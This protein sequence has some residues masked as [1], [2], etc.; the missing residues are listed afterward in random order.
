MISW[1]FNDLC[2]M[3]GELRHRAIR[4]S[5]KVTQEFSG[6]A[7]MESSIAFSLCG[8]VPGR[9]SCIQGG[10]AAL[11]GVCGMSSSPE[12]WVHPEAFG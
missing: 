5:A 6:R 1:L 11:G 7:G 4:D 2:V 8:Q 9:G 10:A 12:L 3:G